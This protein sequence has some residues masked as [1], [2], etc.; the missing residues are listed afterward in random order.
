MNGAVHPAEPLWVN[1]RPTS[2]REI[3]AGDEIEGFAHNGLRRVLVKKARA[4]SAAGTVWLH[5]AS[6]AAIRCLL[7]ERVAVSVGGRRRYRKAS[8]VRPG[9]FLLGMISGVLCVDPVVAIRTTPESVPAVYL[10]I[11]P[12]SLLSEEGLL[13][14][15]S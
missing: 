11:P 6:G 15:P 5:G 14:R 7:D 9:D 4:G 3:K 13:C 2:P 1:G 10:E 8:A 12:I